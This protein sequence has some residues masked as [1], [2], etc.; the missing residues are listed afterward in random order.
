MTR[1]STRYSWQCRSPGKALCSRMWAVCIVC[2]TINALWRP[3]IMWTKLRS[4]AGQDVRAAVERLQHHRLRHR[5][6]SP[7]T[8][9]RSLALIAPLHPA[10]Q[11]MNTVIPSPQ[12][13]RS[14]RSV[15]FATLRGIGTGHDYFLSI[16]NGLRIVSP[17]ICCPCCRSSVYRML[18]P[19]SSAL[20]NC[21]AS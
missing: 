16:S 1:V 21:S 19:F 17:S 3:T 2:T 14:G 6:G 13:K 5:A 10:C 8:A 7:S 20:A 15:P 12:K 4:D 9:T 18:Q 11:S